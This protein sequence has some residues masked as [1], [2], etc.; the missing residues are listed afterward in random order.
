VPAP[1]RA[2][3]RGMD[4]TTTATYGGIIMAAIAAV[5]RIAIVALRT[6]RQPSGP[7]RDPA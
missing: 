6:R 1:A 3:D 4:M 2:D 5:T 7:R